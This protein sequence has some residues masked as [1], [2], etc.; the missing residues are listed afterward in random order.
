RVGP[1]PDQPD[2]RRKNNRIS[3]SIH[4]GKEPYGPITQA[5]NIVEG[6]LNHL[7]VAADHVALLS[8]GAD[9]QSKPLIPRWLASI[10]SVG[11]PRTLYAWAIVR[12]VHPGARP[13]NHRPCDRTEKSAAQQRAPSHAYT[14]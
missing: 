8:L 4:T 5:G 12:G 1:R 2:L 14:P 7:F 6:R 11:R 13:A 10:V 9:S 3:Q